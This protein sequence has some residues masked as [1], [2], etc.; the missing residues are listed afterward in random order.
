MSCCEGRKEI[1]AWNWP[2]NWIVY[3]EVYYQFNWFQLFRLIFLFHFGGLKMHVGL[4]LQNTFFNWMKSNFIGYVD[5]WVNFKRRS[6]NFLQL[7]ELN[8][9]KCGWNKDCKQSIEV[10]YLWWFF[11][12]FYWSILFYIKLNICNILNIEQWIYFSSDAQK[13]FKI[14]FI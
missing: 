13:Y 9:M 8:H 14:I 7:G 11:I 4:S 12:D 3:F 2:T 6:R 5:C 1:A 10:R